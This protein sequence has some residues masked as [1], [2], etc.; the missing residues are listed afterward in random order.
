MVFS[1]KST[2]RTILHFWLGPFLFPTYLG[3]S[4]DL[5][6]QGSF[7]VHNCHLLIMQPI[8]FGL[9]SVLQETFRNKIYFLSTYFHIQE[10]HALILLGYAPK[11]AS[12]C[13]LLISG[14]FTVNAL[15][16]CKQI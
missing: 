8:F 14:V 3:R 15:S 9:R 16:G 10:T 5:C 11:M 1:E 7:A 4:K 12:A 13:W 2:A 6:S